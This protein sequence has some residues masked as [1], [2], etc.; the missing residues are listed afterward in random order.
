MLIGSQLIEVG[1]N[2]IKYNRNDPLKTV[3][4]LPYSGT[5]QQPMTNH[6]AN[7]QAL[8][9]VEMARSPKGDLLHLTLL[10]VVS[11]S[12]CQRLEPTYGCCNER[13]INQ[14]IIRPATQLDVSE[15]LRCH[16]DRDM[17]PIRPG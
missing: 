8:I 6:R 17:G 11:R 9:Q 10:L 13:D 12:A 15:F 7:V 4:N 14:L 3:D 5:L 2:K 16:Q 1:R